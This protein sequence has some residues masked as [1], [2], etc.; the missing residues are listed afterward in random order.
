VI[1]LMSV[2]YMI[3]IK[4]MTLRLN[5]A[6]FIPELWEETCPGSRNQVHSALLSH[7]HHPSL[8]S[9]HLSSLALK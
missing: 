1:K 7:N 8:S 2:L 3:C 4:V 9:H 6:H 5:M